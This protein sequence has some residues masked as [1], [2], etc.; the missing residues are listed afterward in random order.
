I[1]NIIGTYYSELA[2]LAIGLGALLAVVAIIMWFFFPSDKGAEQGKRWFIRI[3][4]CIGLISC[5][6]GII[7]LIQNVTA[8]Q[9]FDASGYITVG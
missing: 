7:S 8:G 1:S 2:G 4:F 6:G 9:G 5:L 3:L